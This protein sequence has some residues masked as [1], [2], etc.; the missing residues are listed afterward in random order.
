MTLNLSYSQSTNKPS[1]L[2]LRT[3]SLLSFAIQHMVLH[4]AVAITSMYLT[5]RTVTLAA[6]SEVLVHTTCLQVLMA[7]IQY[8]LMAMQTFKLLK[9]KYT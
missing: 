6:M 4:L 8:S 1:T 3:I 7:I 9:L 5:T 2:S